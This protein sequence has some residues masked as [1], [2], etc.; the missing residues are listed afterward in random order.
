MHVVRRV[1]IPLMGVLAIAVLPFGVFAAT[2]VSSGPSVVL[3]ILQI[4]WIV[5]SVISFGVLIYG[6]VQMRRSRDDLISHEQAK[7][8]VLFSGIACALSLLLFAIITFFILRSQSSTIST[9]PISQGS[10]IDVGFGSGQDQFANITQHYPTR[11]QRNVSRNV[12][13]LISFKEE[14]NLLST[15]ISQGILNSKAVSIEKLNAEDKPQGCRGA[16]NRGC[17]R[18][19]LPL[20]VDKGHRNHRGSVR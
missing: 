3:R 1:F 18:A 7:R 19:D 6:F 9:P 10:Q 5:A 13:V 11:D 12:I 8:I 15:E 17:V 20:H 4:V 14:L 16:R 2:S